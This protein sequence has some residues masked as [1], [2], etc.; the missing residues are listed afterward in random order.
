MKT[1]LIKTI[2]GLFIAAPVLVSAQ[3]WTPPTVVAPGGNLPAPINV[4]S[5]SQVKSG[6]ISVGSIIITGG[7]YFTGN[8]GIGTSTSPHK[9]SVVGDINLTGALRINGTVGAAGQV[10]QSTGSG[11]AWVATST[12]S[13]A[14]PP[15]VSSYVP[16]GKIIQTFLNVTNVYVNSTTYNYTIPTEC[17]ASTSLNMLVGSYSNVSEPGPSRGVLIRYVSNGTQPAWFGARW[18]G[19]QGYGLSDD[20]EGPFTVNSVRSFSVPVSAL[21]GPGARILFYRDANFDHGVWIENCR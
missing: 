9:L 3:T 18:I 6:G 5:S 13:S 17:T 19:N 20:I 7:S 15:N 16:P 12:L 10:L 1:N 4:S 11:L 21:G 14:T 2:A 8:V